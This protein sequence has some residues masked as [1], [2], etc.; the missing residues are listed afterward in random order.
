M[1]KK[2]DAG[3]SWYIKDNK[4][5][6][7]SAGQNFGQINPNQIQYPSADTNFVENVT[8]GYSMDILSNGFKA[9]GTDSGIN[10]NG[11]SYIYMAIA[12]NPFVTST[13]IPTTAR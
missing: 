5:G 10:T 1:F 9:R 12:E 11:G 2:T 13:G 6:G 3:G 7:T 8:S 4:R